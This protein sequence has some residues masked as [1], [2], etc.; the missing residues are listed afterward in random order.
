M[1]YE[2]LCSFWDFCLFLFVDCDLLFHSEYIT[3]QLSLIPC[4][5]IKE[6]INKY[7]FTFFAA[8]SGKAQIWKY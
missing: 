4:P 8:P 6:V 7:M 1:N 2:L 5:I 3:R